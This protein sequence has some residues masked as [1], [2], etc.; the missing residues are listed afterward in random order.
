MSYS[1][2]TRRIVTRPARSSRVVHAV[3]AFLPL[4]ITALLLHLRHTPRLRVQLLVGDSV[5]AAGCALS[6][7]RHRCTAQRAARVTRQRGKGARGADGIFRVRAAVE[8]DHRDER[9]FRKAYAALE[10]GGDG[11]HRGLRR[12]VGAIIAE[13]VA[14]GRPV[15]ASARKVQ[16]HVAPITEDEEAALA[17]N[18]A[19]GVI[20]SRRPSSSLSAHAAHLG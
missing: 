10:G 12:V 17:T 9:A 11:A 3:G 2:T 16:A 6:H 15:Q 19:L 8:L 4:A 13:E 1:E 5:L 14:V 20:V 7:A 18:A